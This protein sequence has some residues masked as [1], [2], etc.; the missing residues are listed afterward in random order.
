MT[1]QIL[2][3]S[4]DQSKLSFENFFPDGNKNIV[5]ELKNML[6]APPCFD[7]IYLYGASGSGK[8]HLLKSCVEKA[9]NG[10]YIDLQLQSGKLK[11]CIEHSNTPL[12]AIDNFHCVVDHQREMFA[13][14]E[15]LR[16]CAAK[17]V[18]ASTV[19]PMA[20]GLSLNDLSSRLM[21]GKIFELNMLD[22][23]QKVQAL[24]LRAKLRGIEL[25]SE[26]VNYII[27]R[28]PR[29]FKTLFGLLD[30]FDDASLSRQ[31]KITVPF[32]KQLEP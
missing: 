24:K 3:S 21:S 32:I 15:A 6:V 2:F 17:L 18:V 12:L 11:D 13:L 16:Q 25:S 26:V 4:E 27:N 1:Q 19:A 23:T 5:G 8:T 22:D 9:N 10:V 29:D 28:Y 14:F 7:Y 20:L 31:R 30:K